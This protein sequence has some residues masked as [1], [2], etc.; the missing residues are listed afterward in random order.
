MA[1]I[2]TSIIVSLLVGGFYFSQNGKQSRKQKNVRK[3]IP[4]MER[5]SGD[6]VY[7]SNHSQQVISDVMS[8]ASHSYKKSRDPVNQNVI[9]P[10]FNVL[11]HPQSQ[12]DITKKKLASSKKF[13]NEGTSENDEVSIEDSPMFQTLMPQ[14]IGGINEQRNIR[15]GWD[16][17]SG[18]GGS[19]S[20]SSR[21]VAIADREPGTK[22]EHFTGYTIHGPR[23]SNDPSLHNNMVPFIG[24]KGTPAMKPDAQNYRLAMF[25]GQT[26]NPE[27][28]R[29]KPKTEVPSFQDM[30]PNQSY[31]YGTPVDNVS[32]D[33]DR[34]WTS[35]DKTNV[36]PTEQERVG[37]GVNY[38]YG[39]EGRDG[40]HPLYQPPYRSVDELRSYQPKEIYKGRFLS[41]KEMVSNRGIEGRVYKRRPDRFYLNGKD[42]WF[43]TTGSYTA[44]K[45]N[46]Q[47]VAWATD[48]EQTSV[49][50]TGS[51]APTASTRAPRNT[52][53]HEGEV[54]GGGKGVDSQFQHPKRNQFA[55]DLPTNL[56]ANGHAHP[57]T[58]YG[59]GGYLAIDTERNR[60]E[61]QLGSQRLNVFRNEGH[62]VQHQDCARTTTRQTLNVKDYFGGSAAPE[63]NRRPKRYLDDCA[64]TTT[65][66]TVN[67]KDY[68]GTSG[69]VE[70]NRR[71]QRYLD[72]CARTTTRQTLNV[73]DYL[74]GSAPTDGT[75]HPESYD[76]MYNAITDDQK[77]SV[78]DSRIYGPNKAVGPY[79]G[80]CDITMN[81][82]QRTL[83]DKTKY[84]LIGN[85]Y[86]PNIKSQ[87]QSFCN[88][89]T[90]NNRE[91]DGIR[92][93]E[94]YLVDQFRKNPYSQ[95]LHSAPSLSPN[96]IL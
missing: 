81:M 28:Y 16:S 69:A 65:R 59:M 19:T 38:G 26:N 29:A 71:P 45:V 2:A 40:F 39:S 23:N 62:K 57:Y 66:Q 95:S 41:G 72:D 47:F 27:E 60:T 46:E 84:G 36:L 6:N 43:K 80:A 76:S 61:R 7:N 53:R 5:P 78:L 54:C 12:W 20:S 13:I 37:P 31:V 86:Y 34:Y 21:N 4:S 90:Q 52:Y 74:G 92:Q 89:T 51:A 88:T 3:T 44:P 33:R 11:G 1:E 24:S 9:P 18:G 87:D 32:R 96:S 10:N 91:C 83:Y 15:G 63:G 56:F 50:Y 49:D 77:E 75:K 85:K 48:R 17:I 82:K 58:D 25:T 55:Q 8:E 67:V 79:N 68:F 94:N 73:K 64:R 70:G 42:R 22:M 30:T 14:R 93:P 35:N